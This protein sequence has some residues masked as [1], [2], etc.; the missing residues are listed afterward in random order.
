MLFDGMKGMGRVFQGAATVNSLIKPDLLELAA[1]AGLRSIFVG[2]ETWTQITCGITARS[3][4]WGATTV[5]P[6]GGSMT[7]A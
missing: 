1:E 3:R 5:Q 2:F 4:I 6:S 7:R